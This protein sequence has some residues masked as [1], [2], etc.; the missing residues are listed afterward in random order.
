MKKINVLFITILAAT[1]FSCNNDD[2]N[3]LQTCN[4]Q[5]L[6]YTLGSSANIFAL[7][8]DLATDLFPNN[9]IVNNQ[10]VPSVEIYGNDSNGDFVVFTTDVLTINATGT[11]DL[12]IGNGLTEMI[13]VTCLATDNVVG[14][15]MRFQLSGTYNSNVISGEYCVTIDS[16]NP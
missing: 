15:L 6:L 8:A 2:D 14:G 10:S 4:N 9:T 5:G 12:I 3:N 16:V 7:E 11:G 13:N 1:L